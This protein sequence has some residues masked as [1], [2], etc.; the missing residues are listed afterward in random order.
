ML[1]FTD[2]LPPEDYTTVVVLV[3]PK[4]VS[5]EDVSTH[6]SLVGFRKIYVARTLATWISIDGSVVGYIA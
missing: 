4:I 5:A 1:A 3:E 6:D 2:C